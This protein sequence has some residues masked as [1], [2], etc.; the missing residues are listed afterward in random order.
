MRLGSLLFD[1]IRN[2]FVLLSLFF[3]RQINFVFFRDIVYV[4]FLKIFYANNLAYYVLK[5]EKM[6]ND[7]PLGVLLYL[8]FHL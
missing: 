8:Y 4:F 2:S 3:I 7:L 1:D 6:E 5:N